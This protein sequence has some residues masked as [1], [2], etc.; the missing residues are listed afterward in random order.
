M[1]TFE[2]NLIDIPDFCQF[3]DCHNRTAIW[4]EGIAAC[5]KH[6]DWLEQRVNKLLKENIDAGANSSDHHQR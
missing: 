2:E 1:T 4:C 6:E 5:E 3:P